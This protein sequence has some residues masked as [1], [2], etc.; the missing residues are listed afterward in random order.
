M[1]CIQTNV[2]VTYNFTFTYLYLEIP[3]HLRIE[4]YNSK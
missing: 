3:E 1:K 2:F 4:M